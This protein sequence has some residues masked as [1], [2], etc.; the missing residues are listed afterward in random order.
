MAESLPIVTHA[1]SGES[2]EDLLERAK[3]TASR[4]RDTACMALS[5]FAFT[6]GRW[7][8]RPSSDGAQFENNQDYQS[9]TADVGTTQGASLATNTRTREVA[10]RA[11]AE[12]I[13]PLEYLLELMRKPY[14][15]DADGTVLADYDAMKLDAAK[16][17]APYMHPRLANVDASIAIGPLTGDLA[18]ARAQGAGGPLRGRDHTGSG[19]DHHAGHLGAGEDCGGR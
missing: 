8:T 7:N 11:A 18:D 16:A 1:P 12:G 19:G 4:H 15:E 14:P 5:R 13:T 17:A 6:R 9:A 10:D 3:A 2:D